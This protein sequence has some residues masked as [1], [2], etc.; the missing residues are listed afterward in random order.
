MPLTLTP[1]KM[2]IKIK[3]KL[4][5]LTIDW[6]Y[7]IGDYVNLFPKLFLLS[8][9]MKNLMVFLHASYKRDDITVRPLQNDIFR[10]FK[11]C[12]YKELKVI[13]VTEYPPRTFSGN[14]LGLGNKSSI[15]NCCVSQE[16]VEFRNCIE[17]TFYGDFNVHFDWTLTN[18]A[19]QDFL[20]LNTALTCTREDE[21]VHV[22][23]WNGFIRTLLKNLS[24]KNVGL[25]FAFIGDACK[26]AD[27]I[28]KNA[29]CVIQEPLSIHK[30]VKDKE[31]WT[32]DI[33]NEINDAIFELHERNIAITY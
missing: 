23:H 12:P 2:I 29:H 22:P 11:V 6:R 17:N 21:K 14:G 30:C 33:F 31:I 24:K 9:Y 32:T 4:E 26:F 15:S 27:I 5:E 16:L 28:D 1:S 18:L 13:L 3:D 7:L 10:P 8:E 20:L 25:I 19:V